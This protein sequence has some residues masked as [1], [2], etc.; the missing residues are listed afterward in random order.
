[1]SVNLFNIF[2]NFS[3]L[4]LNIIRMLRPH[5]VQGVQFLFDCT[6]GFTSSSGYKGHGCILAD[7]MYVSCNN[8]EYIK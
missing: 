6:M 8:I 5:Q 4:S 2:T 7:D 3:T 1:M